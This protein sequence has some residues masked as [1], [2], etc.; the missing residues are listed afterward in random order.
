MAKK[1]ITIII[2]AYNEEEALPKCLQR[3][4]KLIDKQTSHDFEVLLVDDGSKDKTVEIIKKSA[5][6]T[7]ASVMSLFHVT[8]VKKLP[9]WP[10]ST[11]PKAMR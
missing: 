6:K 11:M 10:V 3:I 2:P 1:L 4:T 5:K 8:S 9:S 7:S